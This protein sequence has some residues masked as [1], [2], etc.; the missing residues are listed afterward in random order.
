MTADTRAQVARDLA[1]ALD[2]AARAEQDAQHWA[3]R[4]RAGRAQLAAGRAEL[5]AAAADAVAR[6]A[7]R[8]GVDLEGLRALSAVVADVHRAA[9]IAHA[10][11]QAAAGAGA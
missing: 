8:L 9:G 10:A 6:R 11:A 1:A 2:T 5:A 4:R 7:R 3:R